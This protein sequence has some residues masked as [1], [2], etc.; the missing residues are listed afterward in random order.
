MKLNQIKLLHVDDEKEIREM[1]KCIL[2]DDVKEF[3]SA[4]NGIEAYEVYQNKKPDVILLDINMP[5]CNGIE[6]AQKLRDNDHSTR[7]IM[8]TACSD[9]EKLL[10]STE[11]KL[12]KYLVKPFSTE[13]LFGALELAMQEI[14]N[15]SII[16]NKIIHLKDKYL[17][18]CRTQT[19]FN[20]SIEINLTPKEREILRI[21]FSN[22][23]NTISYDTLLM[24]VWDD[25][26]N[27]SIDTLK[28]MMKN[29]R[30]K[31]PENTIQ[32]VYGTGFKI[33]S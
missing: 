24:E 17:W 10:L 7:I 26:E 8:T 13:D 20:G 1:M 27:C 29:I 18:N 33:T 2:G 15:F 28:T 23:N 22:L 11:L 16:P 12:T 6:F 9:V 14:Q 32:N 21:L 3:Y 19:L 30:K 4:K 31:L 25:F 5:N